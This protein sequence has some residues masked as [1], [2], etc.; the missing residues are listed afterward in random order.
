MVEFSC[1]EW[2]P[3]DGDRVKGQSE[4][5]QSCLTLC[6]IMDCSPPGSSVHGFFQARI[7]AWLPFPTPGNPSCIGRGILYHCTNSEGSIYTHIFQFNVLYRYSKYIYVYMYTH[8]Y[9][10]IY[11]LMSTLFSPR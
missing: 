6:Y 11:M 10:C 7:L 9:M 8:I 4:V 5:A 2:T 1:F 3:N